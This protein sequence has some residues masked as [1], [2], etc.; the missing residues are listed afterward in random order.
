MNYTLTELHWLY[1]MLL[2]GPSSAVLENPKVKPKEPDGLPCLLTG[3][4]FLRYSR[5][6]SGSSTVMFLLLTMNS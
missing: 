4:Y 5:V 6:G 1:L 2:R 3:N